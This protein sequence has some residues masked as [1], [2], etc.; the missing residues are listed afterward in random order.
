MC[1]SFLVCAFKMDLTEDKRKETGLHVGRKNWDAIKFQ[2]VVRITMISCGW[3]TITAIGL[4]NVVGQG[5][6]MCHFQIARGGCARAREASRPCAISWRVS[7]PFPHCG[8]VQCNLRNLL[9]SHASA[10]CGSYLWELQS[11][12]LV[13]SH[14]RLSRLEI[15]RRH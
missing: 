3:T 10:I 14:K 12:G 8:T 13:G 2:G 11:L 7:S 15:Q 4:V 5:R 9:C 6:R 1:V